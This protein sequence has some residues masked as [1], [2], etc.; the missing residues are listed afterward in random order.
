MII[1][2]GL[3]GAGY[4][5]R[6]HAKRYSLIS[7]V[8]LFAVSGCRKTRAFEFASQY[9][10]NKVYLNPYELIEDKRI[11]IVD[12][13]LPTPLHC[14][15]VVEAAK[16]R[17]HILCE[18]PIALTVNDATK[19]IVA[20]KKAG[21]KFMVAHVLRFWPE[22]IV[23][24]EIVD[25]GRLG[26]ILQI[27]ATRMCPPPRWSSRN[28]ILNQEQSGGVTI[29]LHIHDIDFIAYLLGKPNSLFSTGIKSQEGLCTHISTVLKYSN[30]IASAEASFL[31]PADYGLHAQLRV[32]CENGLIQLDS[33]AGKTLTVFELGKPPSYPTLPEKD[34]YLAEIEYFISCVLNNEEPQ[35]VTPE[36]ARLALQLVLEVK[37][38]LEEGKEVYIL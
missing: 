30:K 16:A 29:D 1:R 32:V 9:G 17:K 8:E 35:I 28:W 14:E 15:F 26:E 33:K 12:I 18:K 11:D 20:T 38:S 10:I 5:G 25:E 3:L 7:G 2:V 6:E 13:C 4:M 37:R 22:Y 23:T 19:M 24:K 21:V 34:G 31:M 27:S 36:D